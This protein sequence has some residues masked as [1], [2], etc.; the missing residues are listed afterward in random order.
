MKQDYPRIQATALG[1]KKLKKMEVWYAS[2]RQ[3]TFVRVHPAYRG[4]DNLGYLK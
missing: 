1:I 2:A 3:K 4:C